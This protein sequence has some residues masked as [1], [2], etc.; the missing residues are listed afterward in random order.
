T[1][2]VVM[3]RAFNSHY[4]KKIGYKGDPKQLTLITN[5][6]KQ[7]EKGEWIHYGSPRLQQIFAHL[8]NNEKYTKLFQ[9]LQVSRKTALYPWLVINVKISYYGKQKKDELL[10]IGLQ[11]VNGMMKFS[12]MDHLKDFSL[13]KTISDYC[14]T[15]SPLIKLNSG[16][17]RIESVLDRHIEQQENDWALRSIDTWQEEKSMLEHFYRGITDEEKHTQ[18]EKEMQEIGDR[19]LPKISYKVINGGLFYLKEDAIT[20]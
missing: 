13:N 15:I 16:F 5:P 17:K 14:F 10:S 12:M 7:N 6:E 8:R 18:M 19:Y 2:K 20:G 9:R 11:L 3:N 1:D 4:M